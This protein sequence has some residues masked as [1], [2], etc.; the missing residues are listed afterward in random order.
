MPHDLPQ[1]AIQ[2]TRK[3]GGEHRLAQF[4]VRQQGGHRPPVAEPFLQFGDGPPALQ[5]GD[6]S[7][8]QGRRNVP[9]PGLPADVLD[10]P[11]DEAP[12]S[13]RQWLD[14]KLIHVNAQQRNRAIVIC[15]SPAGCGVAVAVA[16]IGGENAADWGNGRIDRRSDLFDPRL[17]KIR[18]SQLHGKLSH[19][20]VIPPSVPPFGFFDR[21]VVPQLHSRKLCILV[22]PTW[23]CCTS[24][25][26][27]C[28]R[29]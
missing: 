28:L 9:P 7:A 11:R 23:Q 27:E 19:F 18:L 12:Q 20:S 15:S 14:G 29:R 24:I 2:R 25:S 26:T 16:V 17:P 10:D 21:F 22:L 3:T 13:R 8:V 6:E 1:P 5:A 4:G